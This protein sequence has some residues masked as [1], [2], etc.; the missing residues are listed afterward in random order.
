MAYLIYSYSDKMQVAN[1]AL[2]ATVGELNKANETLVAKDKKLMQLAYYDILTGLANK[3]KLIET[4]DEKIAMGSNHPFTVVEAS[5]DNLKE[6][7]DTYGL[8]TA[9]E[10]IANYAEKVKNICGND[11]FISRLDT[12]RFVI[13]IDGEQEQ[14]NIVSLVSSI[15]NVINEP[16]VVKDIAFKTTMSYGAV[17]FP[18][19]A[20]T[21]E[22]I[23]Q[24]INSCIDY[25]NARG[26]NN[27][28]FFS[29]SS[30]VYVK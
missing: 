12:G 17:T 18:S 4:L 30:S 29:N 5:I 7:T 26:G 15:N 2:T 19:G 3:Q 11:K 23:I 22:R 13:V 8:N 9:D 16:V 25:V 21:S 1:D 27:I 14:K 6:I 20:N 10:I 28:R 24:C